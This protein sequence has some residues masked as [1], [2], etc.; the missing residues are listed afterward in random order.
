[1]SE[2]MKELKEMTGYVSMKEEYLKSMKN[3]HARFENDLDMQKPEDMDQYLIDGE[4]EEDK[5]HDDGSTQKAKDFISPK[6]IE[7]LNK[8]LVKLEKQ[9]PTMKEDIAKK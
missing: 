5:N 2:Y 4:D 7:E 1:M 3:L 8:I 6:K 9:V